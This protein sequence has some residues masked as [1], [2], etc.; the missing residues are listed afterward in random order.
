[1]MKRTSAWFLREVRKQVKVNPNRPVRFDVDWQGELREVQKAATELRRIDS[2][3]RPGQWSLAF[4][5]HP[6]KSNYKLKRIAFLGPD[7]PRPIRIIN[8]PPIRANKK[9]E[10]AIKAALCEPERPLQKTS[11]AEKQRRRKQALEFERKYPGLLQAIKNQPPDPIE[12]ALAESAAGQRQQTRLQNEYGPE[13]YVEMA[14]P[15]V[16]NPTRWIYKIWRGEDWLTVHYA[17]LFPAEIAAL[18]T[19]GES[20][21][22]AVERMAPYAH[23]GREMIWRN[24]QV[25]ASGGKARST[26]KDDQIETAFKEY[27]RRNPK[28]SYAAAEMKVADDLGYS[29]HR[30]L[31]ERVLRMKGISPAEWYKTML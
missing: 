16:M 7:A 17:T 1:M 19:T 26:C 30:K 20:A 15:E 27:K 31:G 18:L 22:H 11:Y 25:A 29:L 9:D 24:Q 5:E 23:K 28:H 2:S 3:G 13:F 12:I 21:R 10:L 4:S 6:D 8:G 14:Q